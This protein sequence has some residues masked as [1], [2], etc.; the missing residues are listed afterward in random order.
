MK[1][2]L[3][4]LLFVPFVVFGQNNLVYLPDASFVNFLEELNADLIV[5]DS[6]DVDQ[7]EVYEGNQSGCFS[8]N[9]AIYDLEGVQYFSNINCLFILSGSLENIPN[10]S[11]LNNLATLVV[12]GCPNLSYFEGLSNLSSLVSL[13]I[14]ETGLTVVPDLSG[15]SSLEGLMIRDNESLT[16]VPSLSGLSSL[17][18]LVIRDN[19]SLTTV[20]SLSGLTNL[21]SL[22]FGE[23]SLTSIP[24]LSGLTNLES[25]HVSEGLLTSVP[26][27][28]ELTNLKYVHI[29]DCYSLTNL[30]ELSGLYNL[31]VLDVLNCYELTELPELS[32]LNNLN[33]I[34]VGWCNNLI[35]IPDMSSLINLEYLW[36]DNNSSL[37]CIGGYPPQLYDDMLW[38]P[39]ICTDDIL[40]QIQQSFNA[41][42]VSINLSS[43]WNLFGYGCPRSIYLN[44]GLS[45]YVDQ[46]VIVKDNGGNVYLP[47]YGYNSIG[48]LTPGYG[49][50]IKVTEEINDFNLCGWYVNHIPEDNIVSLQ[51]EVENL[52]E[53]NTHLIDSLN[54]VNSQ[55]G[56][57]DSLAC[58]FNITNLYDDG[59]CEYTIQGY[60][61]FGDV[62]PHYQVGDLAHGGIVFYVDESGYHGLVAELGDLTEG[63]NDPN[64]WGFNGYEWGCKGEEVFNTNISSIGMGYANSMFIVSH[65]CTSEEGGVIA[66]QAAL[67]LEINGYSDWYLPSRDELIEMY[68]TIGNGGLEP[69]IA[70]FET[71][72]YPY[73]WS[74]TEFYNGYG[75]FAWY[76]DL[77]NG[78]V[79]QGGKENPSRVRVIRSF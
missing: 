70:G 17:E 27:L 30:P 33:S 13:N 44:D 67:D 64:D 78:N 24:N 21:T 75:S 43:G 72:L 18:S 28:S 12:Y 8:V 42:N 37:E 11:G 73:Y 53:E 16:T 49:Y 19:E 57:T 26:N 2:I 50:Q 65:G 56:C 46:I 7:A 55:I 68:N 23:N 40:D 47:E 48:D 5:N 34:N 60:D 51:E 41:W 32:G 77:N 20:P 22:S 6:L 9:G 69:N 66:A 79:G 76:V 38:G 35:S 58:N 74:S 63:A 52:N 29:T 62:L 54:M 59:S 61:C 36:I 14:E 4:I 15:L 71:S 1:K 39:P 31:R 10:L 3:Y 25:L 45:N